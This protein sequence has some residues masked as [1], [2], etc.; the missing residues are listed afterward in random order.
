MPKA[1][2]SIH[3]VEH[4]SPMK[5]KTGEYFSPKV[6]HEG[7]RIPASEV[8]CVGF[9]VRTTKEFDKEFFNGYKGS[10]SRSPWKTSAFPQEAAQ[11]LFIITNYCKEHGFITVKDFRRLTGVTDYHTRLVLDGYCEGEFP[12]M[13]REKA[14]ATYVYPVND[15]ERGRRL[16]L[17]LYAPMKL[18]FIV[19]IS[20]FNIGIFFGFSLSSSSS[21]I[22]ANS[23]IFLCAFPFW[24]REKSSV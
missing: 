6:Y 1:N 8:V 17:F 12:K 18:G 13:T 21:L 22:M 3:Y 20:V 14:G 10:C 7:D 23:T 2:G 11:E 19:C 9:E 15:A 16:K 4:R 5:D 24:L